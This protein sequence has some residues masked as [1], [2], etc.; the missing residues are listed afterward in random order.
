MHLRSPFNRCNE[1]HHIQ[2]ELDLGATR[3]LCPIAA[4]SVANCLILLGVLR[5]RI[6]LGTLD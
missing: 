5:A 3:S 1:R 4:P 2:P 6:P